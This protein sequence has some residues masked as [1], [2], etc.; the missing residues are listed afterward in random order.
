MSESP[1]PHTFPGYTEDAGLV[2]GHLSATAVGAIVQRI[3]DGSAARFADVAASVGYCSK[4]IRLVGSSQTIDG[5]TGEILGSFSSDDAPL[6]VAYRPCGNRRA[7]VC[8]ACS[9]VYARDT[10]AMVRAGLLG[11][12][13]VPQEVASNPLVF[14]TL[15][16]PSFGHVHGVRAKGG[17][18]AGGRCRPR[19]TAD[20]CEHGRPVGCMA[21]HT[22]DDPDVGGPLCVDCYDWGSAVVWQWWAPELWRR[23]TITLRRSLASR[24]G[25]SESRLKERASVQFA[26]V[27]EYQARG[28][29]TSTRLCGST[30]RAGRGRWL[31]STAA[32]WRT[33][34]GR[35][36]GRCPSSLRRSTVRT[37]RAGLPSG[38]SSTREP[39]APA[40]R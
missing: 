32:A 11:G 22:D 36:P 35:P 18:P 10:F 6:G 8:A 40:Y 24:L 37:C 28:L 17:H 2:L 34:S 1:G 13:T 23:F 4:P 20:R 19:D 29:V 9:R 15:T 5:R 12:K 27:A 21:V 25:A 26:K 14:A 39:C 33:S 38:R 7:D 16:A 30:V 3:A 31:R